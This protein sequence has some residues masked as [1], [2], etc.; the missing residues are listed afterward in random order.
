[1]RGGFCPWAPPRPALPG[2]RAVTVAGAAGTA[3]P[4]PSSRAVAAL[5]RA[6]SSA[7]SRISSL[8][9]EKAS[10]PAKTSA[11]T[12]IPMISGSRKPA[13]VGAATD[14]VRPSAECTSS[15]AMPV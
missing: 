11:T 6:I 3:G 5:I 14:T 4:V 13:A 7:S 15:A 2:Q 8:V 12:P 10:T 1:L 9:G